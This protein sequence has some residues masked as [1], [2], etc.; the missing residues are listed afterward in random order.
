VYTGFW[1]NTRGIY[2]E[3]G[4]RDIVFTDLLGYGILYSGGFMAV[5]CSKGLIGKTVRLS[6]L[7]SAAP[8]MVVIDVDDEGSKKVTVGWLDKNNSY[9]NAVFPSSSLDKADNEAGKAKT[10]PVKT[11][12]RKKK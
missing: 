8:V 9:N 1:E 7:G 10:R 6:A 3:T 4:D 5:V 12:V 11:T 2:F